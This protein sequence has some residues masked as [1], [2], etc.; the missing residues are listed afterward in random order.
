MSHRVTTLVYSR[1]AGSAVRKGVLSYMADRA[2]DDGSGVWCSKQT[3]ADDTEFGR[4]TI[5]RTCNDFVKE[6]IL[7]Q[8]GTRKCA[9]G[10]T[11][12]YALNLDAIKALPVSKKEDKPSHSGTSPDRD[13]SHSGTSGVSERD[14]MPSRSGT[15]TI[16]EPSLNQVVAVE[17]GSLDDLFSDLLAAIGL[18]NGKIPTYWMPPTATMHVSKWV[19]DLGLTHSEIL[20]VAK[21]SRQRHAEPPNGPKALDRAMAALAGEKSA[22]ALTPQLKS[23]SGGRDERRNQGSA[24]NN[25]IA[26]R[27]IA[28]TYQH[29]PFQ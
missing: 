28:G 12:E 2:N 16:L 3:M 29:D 14:P 18:Q 27:F 13:P 21:S 10:A 22:P 15:Q 8:V 26:A 17:R 6:A 25:E 1:R 23:M 4:S 11:V 20:A 24:V 19:A 9:S 7:I 5:I